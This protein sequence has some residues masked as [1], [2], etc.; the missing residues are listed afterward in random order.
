MAKARDAA[1]RVESEL[2]SRGV[3]PAHL[4]VGLAALHAWR[5]LRRV[6]RL[7]RDAAALASRVEAL[8]AAALEAK[9]ALL[10]AQKVEA[11]AAGAWTDVSK[12]IKLPW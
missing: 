12:A 10:E 11:N 1:G 7:E 2:R 8:E 4:L 6:A 5:F 9:K 3:D